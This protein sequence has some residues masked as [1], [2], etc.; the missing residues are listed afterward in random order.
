MKSRILEQINMTSAVSHEQIL[1]R[2]FKL[3]FTLVKFF[4]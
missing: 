1:P 3:E 2:I 4:L